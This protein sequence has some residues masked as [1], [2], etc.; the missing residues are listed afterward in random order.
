MAGFSKDLFV[1]ATKRRWLAGFWMKQ[2]WIRDVGNFAYTERKYV[3]DFF[4]KWSGVG[5]G[6]VCWFVNDV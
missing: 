1:D 4:R 3:G 2:G 6:G 5:F